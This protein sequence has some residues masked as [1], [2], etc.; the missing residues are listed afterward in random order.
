MI[1]VVSSPVFPEEEVAVST[2]HRQTHTRAHAE[3]NSDRETQPLRFLIFT[4]FK[5]SRHNVQE[6]SLPALESCLCMCVCVFVIC[7]LASLLSS[8]WCLALNIVGVC[9]LCIILPE[10]SC[11]CASW[12]WWWCCFE[13]AGG[14]GSTD[15]LVKGKLAALLALCS[16][17][18]QV[19]WFGLAFVSCAMMCCIEHWSA[20]MIQHASSQEELHR[21][22]LSVRAH[23][24]SCAQTHRIPRCTPD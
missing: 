3:R 15:G 23:S 7:S 14:R 11:W 12:W 13:C 19:C 1:G 8:H 9:C 17:V 6:Y 5:G 21:G 20:L 10:L 4:H 18:L 16:V 24:K 22:R 2:S